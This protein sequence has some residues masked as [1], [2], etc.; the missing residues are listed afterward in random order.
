VVGERAT[1]GERVSLGDEESDAEDIEDARRKRNPNTEVCV[2]GFIV[3]GMRSPTEG[4]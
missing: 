2:S 4:G 3:E 1:Q